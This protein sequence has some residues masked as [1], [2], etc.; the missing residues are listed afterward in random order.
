MQGGVGVLSFVFAG[1]LG[2]SIE[3][4]L[5]LVLK[6]MVVLVVWMDSYIGI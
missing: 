4:V 6:V 2:C 1:R 5:M 3:E